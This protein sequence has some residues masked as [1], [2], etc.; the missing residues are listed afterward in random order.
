[1]TE[2]HD[3]AAFSEY[4][5]EIKDILM[6]LIDKKSVK[7]KSIIE[8]ILNGKTTK[9]LSDHV[10]LQ[11][12]KKNGIFFTGT[13][14]S[15][16]VADKIKPLLNDGMS[17][18]DPACGAGNLLLSCLNHLPKKNT[19]LETLEYWS[20]IVY[21]N[22]LYNEFINTA[23]LRFILH[24]INCYPNDKIPF[25]YID[26]Y[27]HNLK[28]Q[29]SLTIGKTNT[30]NTCVVVNPPFGYTKLD[31]NCN[32]TGGKFQTAGLFIEKIINDAHDGQHIVAILPDVLRSGSRYEKWRDF[33]CKKSKYLDIETCGRF[34]KHAD[35]D[36]FILHIIKSLSPGEVSFKNKQTSKRTISNY[37]NICVGPVVPHRDPESGPLC[38]YIHAKTAPAN[39]IINE[40]NEKKRYSG[41]TFSSP[42]LTIHRTS[43]PS[44]RQRCKVTVIDVKGT[45]A[46]EN[47]LIVLTPKDNSLETCKKFQNILCLRETTEWL[48]EE[49]RCRHLTVSSIK[50]LPVLKEKENV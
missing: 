20:N 46:V 36:V 41:R 25:M 15:E 32:W 8:N 49:I 48:N 42:F 35:V 45:V 19:L 1:M 6:N 2:E 22:D 10:S 30:K 50:N 21:G 23:K 24:A 27:F 40:I 5:Y 18:I 34:D 13:Q 11:Y 9:A 43:S 44:D 3:I 17:V 12:R 37:F 29:N 31:R 14:L 39:Q 33:I 26:K 28:V 16:K 4:L 7:S 38:K 47:H